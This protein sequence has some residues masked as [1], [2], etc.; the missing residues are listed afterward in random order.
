[1]FTCFIKNGQ[2]NGNGVELGVVDL[3]P[4]GDI[5]IYI[6]FQR[7]LQNYEEGML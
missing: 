1:M 4:I 5:H 3:G 2:P 7:L 6:F